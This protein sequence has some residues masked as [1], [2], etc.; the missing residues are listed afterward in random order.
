ML[1]MVL[2]W[3]RLR[4][5]VLR[6]LTRDEL[7]ATAIRHPNAGVVVAPRLSEQA[8][9]RARRSY[10]HHSVRRVGQALLTLT[11]A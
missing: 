5:L 1:G 3:L 4:R 2:E 9:G 10:E 11:L 8:R 7:A 6:R